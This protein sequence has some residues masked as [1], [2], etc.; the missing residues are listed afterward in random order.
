MQI[1][2]CRYYIFYGNV[3]GYGFDDQRNDYQYEEILLKV[4]TFWNITPRRR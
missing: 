1:R 3:T 2:G 4:Y